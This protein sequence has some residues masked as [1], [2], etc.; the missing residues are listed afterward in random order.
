MYLVEFDNHV[1]SYEEQPLQIGYSIAGKLHH[2]TPDFLI[3]HDNSTKYIVEVKPKKKLL[4]QT[5][6]NRLQAVA[7]LFEEQGCK[8]LVAADDMIRVQPKLKNIKLLWK[9]ARTPLLTHYQAFCEDIFC[10]KPAIT[11]SD[12]IDFF[13]SKRLGR[14]VVFALIFHRI[15]EF[16]LMNPLSATS[17]LVLAQNVIWPVE[18]RDF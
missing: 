11:L 18:N 7:P 17:T 2:Y 6:I 12:L 13:A 8:F 1:L 15:I 3:H 5:I 14:E 10:R 4:D 9:Y 16:D